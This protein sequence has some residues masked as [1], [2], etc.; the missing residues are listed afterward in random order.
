[1]TFSR[2]LSAVIVLS[3]LSSW[4]C[5]T[6]YYVDFEGGADTNVGTSPAAAFKHCPGDG[7]ATGPAKGTTLKPGDKVIF[8]GGVAYKGTVTC[9]SSGSTGQPVTYDGNTAGTFGEGRAVIDGSEPVTG[10]R[11]CASADECGGNPHWQQIYYA[12]IPAGTDP[13]WANLAQGD[14]LLAVA[15]DPNL[16][17]MLFEDDLSCF[18]SVRQPNPKSQSGLEIIKGS[19]MA[20]NSNRPYIV[21]F[22]GKDG[23]SGII[24]P[25]IGASLTF[26]FSPAVTVSS[27][28]IQAVPSY[29]MPRELSLS[30]DRKEILAATLKNESGMQR[31]ALPRP[32]TFTSLTFK[33][34]NSYSEGE[35]YGAVAEIQG[36]DAEGRNVLLSP[37]VMAYKDAAY[38]T[39]KDPHYWDGASFVLW[40]RPNMIYRCDVAGY[41]PATHTIQFDMLTAS[42]Y[43]STGKFAMMN[44]LGILDRP[45]EYVVDKTQREDGNWRVYA[46]PLDDTPDGIARSTRSLA[47]SVRNVSHV[48]VQGFRICRQGNAGD[49]KAIYGG[50]QGCKGIVIRDN[51]ITLLRSGRSPTIYLADVND[52]T[53]AGNHIHTNKRC[54]GITMRS[55][56]DCVIRDNLLDRNGATGLIL[57]YSHNVDVLNN[58]L[59]EH[60]GVHANGLTAYLDCSAIL[61]EGNRVFDGNVCLTTQQCKHVTVRNNVFDGHGATSAIGLWNV[62]TLVDLKI[63]NNL[64]LRSPKDSTWAAAIYGGGRDPKGFVIRNNVIDGLSGDIS[65]EISHNIW[66]RW[67]PSQPEKRLGEGERYEPDLRKIFVDPDA[68]DYRLRPGSPAIDAGVDVGVERDIEGTPVPQGKAPDVGPY[69]HVEP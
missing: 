13:F 16:E 25:C 17:D 69:E 64:I 51:E 44:A 14:R 11:R 42:Q 12:P 23:T 58:T 5:A 60:K 32:V 59:R 6:T 22:D 63:Y 24:D 49:A 26:R 61:F 62:G 19:G 54:A 3:F 15:Q 67:G 34:H 53:I 35:S 68:H 36:Y 47:F 20:E 39:Q 29:Q 43:E 50:G 46:W 52:S 31:F 21:M 28:G 40:A 55:G 1:M 65:G 2:Q 8:K 38:F 57:Y 48:T 18:R 10:W 56:N 30:A 66:T 45:G 27:F 37:P 9:R 4:A 33:V 7:Q 41:D